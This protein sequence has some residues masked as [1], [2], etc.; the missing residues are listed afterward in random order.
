[1]KFQLTF[2]TPDAFDQVQRQ[3]EGQYSE[4][5][6]GGSCIDCDRMGDS[7]REDAREAK[8]VFD[9]FVKYG[10]VIVIELDTEE[11]TATVVK[12]K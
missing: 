9:S 7:Q 4:C 2:K 10:E 3:I 12:N 11:K 5:D 1:M 8:E 6:C